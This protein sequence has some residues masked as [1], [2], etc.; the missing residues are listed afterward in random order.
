MKKILFI[1]FVSSLIIVFSTQGVMGG[2]TGKI[3]GGC[4]LTI[5]NFD[6][7]HLGHQEII[8]EAGKAAREH[9]VGAVAAMT[10]YPHPATILHPEKSPGVLT[11]LKLKEKLLEEHGV[12]YLIVLKDSYELLN[13]SPE[14]FVDE[15][16]MQQISPWAVI[17]GTD[18]NFGYGR[19]GGVATLQE[20][21]K[22]RGFEVVVIKPKK[23]KL[24]N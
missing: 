23:I 22:K 1:L 10:F 8:R 21:G 6:G 17:E 5:G 19:S 2:N 14:V 4:V 9:N 18:F 13:L 24:S 15:F 16:L 3:A 12:D 20:L 11:P 7:V